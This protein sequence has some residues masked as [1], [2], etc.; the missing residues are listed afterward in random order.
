MTE[1]VSETVR[2]YVAADSSLRDVLDFIEEQLQQHGAGFKETMAVTVAAEEIFV[3][4][5]HYAYE[6]KTGE[7]EVTV[8][9]EGN[10][11]VVSMTDSGV[12]FNP[13][14]REEPDIKAEAA[15]RDIGGLGILMVRR[16]MDD[17]HYERINTK[18]V[19][20]MR[21]AVIK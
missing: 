17:C 6:G 14:L 1:H 15:E 9:F 7:A 8:R 4:I 21:K 18:N 12:A 16:T 10:D 20:T 5:A 2:T 19:F 3:N 13:L 11:I